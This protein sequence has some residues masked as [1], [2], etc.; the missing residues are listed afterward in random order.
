MYSILFLAFTQLALGEIVDRI[1]VVVD[2]QLIFSS[3]I[4]LEERMSRYNPSPSPFWSSQNKN[5]AQR[6]IDGAIIRKAA[7][8]IRLYQPTETQVTTRLNALKS[9]FSSEHEWQSFIRTWAPEE[10][11]IRV[12]LIR[13]M[14]VER[15][16]ARTLKS[17]PK[18]VDVWLTECND[19][20]AQLRKHIEVRHIPLKKVR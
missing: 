2:D 20:V 16:L 7:G 10:A 4:E 11:S 13:Q 15:Y 5:P 1:E 14:V 19:H 18:D 9:Q 17:D 6:L 3:E 8:T 12:V